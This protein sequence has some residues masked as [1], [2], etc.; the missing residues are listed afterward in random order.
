M[1]LLAPNIVI[2]F[3][4]KGVSSVACNMILTD[5]L[6][7]SRTA[8]H[9]PPPLPKPTPLTHPCTGPW[10]VVHFYGSVDVEMIKLGLVVLSLVQM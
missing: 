6:G 5:G 8:L 10:L 3:F 9:C 4:D 2:L 1:G 7:I